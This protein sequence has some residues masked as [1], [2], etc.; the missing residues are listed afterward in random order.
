MVYDALMT[1]LP[2]M[3]GGL[4]I[5]VQLLVVLLAIGLGLGL[6]L[7]L[8]E[9]Y[10]HWSLRLLGI[11]FE[12]V[13]RGVPAVVLL[14]VFYY[15]LAGLYDISSFAAAALALGLRSTAYQ[16]QIFRGAIQS[17]APGQMVA[18]RAIGM[19]APAALHLIVLP[20]ALRHAIGPWTNEFSS[21]LKAT[22]LAYVIGVVELTRQAK[23]VVSNTQGNVL[24]VFALVAFIYFLVN[25]AGNWGLYR[26]ER[27]LA[28]PGFETRGAQA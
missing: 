4:W 9:V 27:K 26:F 1:Q 13:F 14:F 2:Y 7:A 15:G 19:S 18:A 11:A 20:Q 21:E 28:V 17:V 3:L 8:L 10:G 16:S 6:G 23:Y 25:R 22:S 24:L 12:R 5:A